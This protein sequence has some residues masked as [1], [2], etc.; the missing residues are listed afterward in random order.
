MDES[1]GLILQLD[2]PL[3]LEWIWLL[4]VRFTAP[5]FFMISSL[6]TKDIKGI[7]PAYLHLGKSNSKDIVMNEMD[8]ISYV[9][10][11]IIS[12]LYQS[13]ITLFSRILMHYY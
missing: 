12:F 5:F 9:L 6:Q 2:S 10:C 7:T 3:P 11:N 1:G 8:V 4:K 13:I